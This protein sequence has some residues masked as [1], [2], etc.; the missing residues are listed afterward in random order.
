M[1]KCFLDM[2]CLNC[3]GLDPGV[4]KKT[5]LFLLQGA[6]YI[7]HKNIMH[8]SNTF[9]REAVNKT[10]PEDANMRETAQSSS[11]QVMTSP[12]FGTTPLPELIKI[13]LWGTRT[14][15]NPNISFYEYSFE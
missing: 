14:I 2:Y 9:Y 6:I 4:Q 1:F 15:R 12:L 13:K 10:K 3:F 5:P 11:P 7:T 8:L